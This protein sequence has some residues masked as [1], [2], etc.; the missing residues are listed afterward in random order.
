MKQPTI[1]DPYPN[2][3]PAGAQTKFVNEGADQ[4]VK[5]EPSDRP[6]T[7]EHIKK[8]RKSFKNA[9]GQTI[10]HYGKVDDTLP[11][12]TFTYGL[13]TAGSDHVPQ[14]LTDKQLEG[15]KGYMRDLREEKYA[16]NIKEPLGKTVD[17][18][19]NW[20][21]QTQQGNFQFGVPTRGSESAKDVMYNAVG[22]SETQQ[23]KDLYIKSHGMHEAGQQKNRDYSWPFNPKDQVF[24]KTDKN[25]VDEGRY[26]LQPETVDENFPKTQII[27]KNVEDFRD[28]NRDH[29]GKTKN[30]AQ[31]N[32]HVTSD[33]VYGYKPKEQDP[34]NAAKCITGESTFKDVQA[35]DSLG[36]ATRFGYKNEVKPGDESRVFGLPTIRT[37]VQKPALRS[38]ADPYNYGDESDSVGLLF[39]QR[40]AEMGIGKDDFEALRPKEQI[41]KMFANIGFA[42]KPGKFEGVFMRAQEI[43]GSHSDDVSVRAFIQAIK[44]M[45]HV[46]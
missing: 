27:K 40:F 9:A 7:P 29:L 21:Q 2:Y 36:R 30:L 20:P 34:W 32:S 1:Y 46:E 22:I 16:K 19:Y 44:E 13:G 8:Y 38:V 24:G 10:T 12:P 39:P 23:T 6:A 11:E 33:H 43:C 3:R 5:P 35:E 4:C 28:Y 41:R 25:V 14:V 42:Y 31:T 37:D 17:R 15:V 18:N 26:C 45:D